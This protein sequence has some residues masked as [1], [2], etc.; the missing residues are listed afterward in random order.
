MQSRLAE[1]PQA[2]GSDIDEVS[3]ARRMR[4]FL[5]DEDD[6]E[7]LTA[8]KATAEAHQAKVVERFY[9]HML[10]N[11]E[12]RSIFQTPQ[13]VENLKR[14][15]S[16]YF[17]ELFEGEYGARYLEDRIRVGKTH[18]RIGL[19]PTW[20]IGAYSLYMATLLP[21]VLE[22][23]EDDKERGVE[24]FRSLMKLICFDMSIAIDTYISAMAEREAAQVRSF[25]SA[26][27]D[28]ASSLS[29]SSSGI[30]GVTATQTTAA[31]Q[32]ATA[33]AEVTSTLS[34][35]RQ[36][37]AQA[38]EKA[39]LV[40]GESDRSI[41]ASKQGA[42]AVEASV[43]AM[44]QI[45]EKV[46][47]I[48]HKIVSLS[49]K[50][51][52]IGEII[53][54]VNEIAEQS[55]LLALNAAIEAARAGEHGKGFAVVAAEIRSLA[56]QSKQSTVQVRKILGD[57]QGA[58]SSAVIAT[59]E[60][61]KQVEVGLSLANR[62]GEMLQMLGRTVEES[63][64]AARLIANASRQQT[65][66]VQQVADAMSSINEAMSHAVSGLRQ[67]ELSLKQLNDT[68]QRVNELVDSFSRPKAKVPEYRL[69]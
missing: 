18:E 14:T 6:A 4:F 10:S 8:F 55:K 1:P 53:T 42:E 68:T 58:T 12:T 51:Q 38:L 21:I 25:V 37:S 20:Y 32:Q 7:R 64:A 28:F 48:A 9:E 60:G 36:T 59:E 56:E 17:A 19:E 30:L 46:D 57:I 5:F 66:G 54:S 15:Q 52:Q 44:Q 11:E 27:T 23:Y 33:I 50:T 65:A 45:R 39:E 63:A 35:L 62:S 24:T 2:A 41:D 43:S 49:E 47:A 40:I 29:D 16:Q 31:Q 61:T 34:E 22:A 13:H 69:A 26:L 3:F 67:S